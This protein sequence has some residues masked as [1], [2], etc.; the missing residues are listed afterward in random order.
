LGAAADVA[1]VAIT[2]KRVSGLDLE[3]C[4]TLTFDV[5]GSTCTVTA[6][7]EA[8]GNAVTAAVADPDD[9][10]Q[11]GSP[12]PGQVEFVVAEGE[13]FAKGDTLAVVSAMKMEVKVTAPFDLVI[14]TAGVAIGER[15]DEGSLLL[16]VAEQ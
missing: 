9:P 4:R 11:I 16:T 12:L 8:G 15:V 14:A 6:K 13:K 3:G 1:S 5:N 10:C 7:D 2:L